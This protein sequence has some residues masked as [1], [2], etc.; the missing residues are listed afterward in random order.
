MKTG[1]LDTEAVREYLARHDPDTITGRL[2]EV[3]DELGAASGDRFVAE[4]ARHLL[5]RVEW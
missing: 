4:T 5:Q 1:Q 3:A 2:D